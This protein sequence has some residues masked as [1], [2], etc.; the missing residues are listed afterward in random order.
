MNLTLSSSLAPVEHLVGDSRAPA[1]VANQVPS[2]PGAPDQPRCR[3]PCHTH[4]VR[5]RPRPARPVLT[6]SRSAPRR[7]G[8]TRTS[9]GTA[10]PPAA[11]TNQVPSGP[12]APDQPRCRPRCRPHVVRDNRPSAASTD[13]VPR[14][15]PSVD[16]RRA[17]IAGRPRLT[18][19]TSTGSRVTRAASSPRAPGNGIVRLQ[20]RPVR[21]ATAASDR[22]G[23]TYLTSDDAGSAD[24]SATPTEQA[25]EIR[26]A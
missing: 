16:G 6:R 23:C 10:A 12:G 11:E 7:R 22:S 5:D 25:C 4:V 3:H 24:R 15:R 19:C 1:A 13:Q 26:E 17:A 8:A 2:G 9:S 14:R 21:P 20:R 18:R